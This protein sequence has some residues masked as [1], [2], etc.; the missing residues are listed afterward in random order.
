MARRLSGP[1]K[2][3]FDALLKE[4]DRGCVRVA[5][6]WME[7]VLGMT[8]DGVLKILLSYAPRNVLLAETQSCRNSVVN[9]ALSRANS[10]VS[11]CRAIGMLDEPTTMALTA[12][13]NLRNDHFAHVAG[14]SRLSDRLVKDQLKNLLE[15]AKITPQ[16]VQSV[17]PTAKSAR[18][19]SLA[20]REFM[21]TIF[22]L[23]AKVHADSLKM[24]TKLDER[25]P[26][27]IYGRLTSN[28][29]KA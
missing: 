2:E 3:I 27:P 15:A 7:D 1:P 18:Q 12:L 26:P 29:R 9:G 28:A 10:R 4:S 17:F 6:A 5:A 23:T 20:R 24:L 25:T 11:F 19:F 22:F 21:S 14:V 13:F 8:I 16:Y